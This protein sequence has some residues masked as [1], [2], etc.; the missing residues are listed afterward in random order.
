MSLNITFLK[1]LPYFP[2][3]SEINN[4]MQI[5]LIAQ[6]PM[7]AGPLWCPLH[8]QVINSHDIKNNAWV[9]LNNAFWV[10]SEAICQWFSRVTKSWVKIIGKS[11][12]EWPK[13][14]YS[15]QQMY[16]FIS[17]TLLYVLNTQFCEKHSKITHFAIV[18]NDGRFWLSIV[19]SPQLICDV[20]RTRDTSIVT[21]YLS[22]VLARA[23]WSKGDLH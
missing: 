19:T 11:P 3:A 2:G 1:L 5:K 17:Y 21:S 14:R 8:P 20:T 12:H 7:A 23:N 6:L 18:A 16:Y 10:T 22:I 9:T 13:N 15:R 4:A